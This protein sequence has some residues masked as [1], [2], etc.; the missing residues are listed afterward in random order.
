MVGK[1]TLYKCLHQDKRAGGNLY[2]F[3]RHGLK[4]KWQR[5]AIPK[6]N[7]KRGR[8][9]SILERPE[10]IDKQ[11]HM[12]DMYCKH[13]G[14]QIEGDST[15]CK[16]C[17]NTVDNRKLANSKLTRISPKWLTILITWL[18]LNVALWFAFAHRSYGAEHRT[19]FPFFVIYAFAFPVFVGLIYYRFKTFFDEYKIIKD[20]FVVICFIFLVFVIA[21]ETC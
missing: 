13:C 5:L 2:S 12:G 1:S 7:K 9:K 21:E 6:N 20:I 19:F 16:Y 14:K 18:I 15:F 4:Y 3:C 17:G 10:I 11:G 8:Y